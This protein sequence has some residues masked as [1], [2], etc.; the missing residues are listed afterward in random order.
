M[1]IYIYIFKQENSCCACLTFFLQCRNDHSKTC[2]TSVPL[3]STNYSALSLGGW[4]SLYE[5]YI[6]IFWLSLQGKHHQ[7]ANEGGCYIYINRL[8]TNY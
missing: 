2:A 7:T 3:S 1:N 4:S 6:V 8:I 5:Q